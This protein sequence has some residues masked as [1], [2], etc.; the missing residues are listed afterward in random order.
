MSAN[1]VWEPIPE[2]PKYYS[3]GYLTYVL[4]NKY[5]LME[6]GSVILT[7]KDIPYLTGICDA[8]AGDERDDALR[9]INAINRHKKVKIYLQY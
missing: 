9:L 6:E 3:I 4:K 7:E 2:R 1:L 8:S 5:N